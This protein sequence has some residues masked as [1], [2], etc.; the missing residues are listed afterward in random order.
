MFQLKDVRYPGYNAT[1]QEKVDYANFEQ[2]RKIIERIES[3]S[4]DLDYYTIFGTFDLDRLE[5]DEIMV[6]LQSIN[7][8][9]TFKD[10]MVKIMNEASGVTWFWTLPFAV[11]GYY[12]QKRFI[13]K[14]KE[15]KE[16]YL[17]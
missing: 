6:L 16:E 11:L 1:R 10:Y 7:L 3:Y 8:N 9:I 5:D 12:S 2:A 13:Q 4:K 14:F 15:N 17:I